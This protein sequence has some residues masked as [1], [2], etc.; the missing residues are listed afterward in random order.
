MAKKKR[1]NKK[2]TISISAKKAELFADY[3]KSKRLSPNRFLKKVIDKNLEG[4]SGYVRNSDPDPKQL[5][6]FD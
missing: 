3:C 2:I 1:K 6:L 5:G 4:F